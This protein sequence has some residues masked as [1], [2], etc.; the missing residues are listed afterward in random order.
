VP[1][2]SASELSLSSAT[3]PL[4]AARLF[5][6]LRD[7][8][9]QLSRSVA[10]LH[11]LSDVRRAVSSS[12]Y[13]RGGSL[14]HCRERGPARSRADDGSLYEYDELTETLHRSGPLPLL[15]PDDV[16]EELADPFRRRPIRLGERAVEQAV[17]TRG[18]VQ[19][20]DSWYRAATTVRSAILSSRPASGSGRPAMTARP[21][22]DF[23]TTPNHAAT[24]DL[25]HV[26]RLELRTWIGHTDGRVIR[27]TQESGPLWKWSPI[28]AAPPCRG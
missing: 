17:S 6:A 15:V 28:L 3:G 5:E 8:T 2:S 18:P 19:I 12:H 16:D 14:D 1:R 22:R 11:A 25:F 20:P 4:R 26:L 13:I 21:E 7:R 24:A 10:E 23:L 9:T 27:D